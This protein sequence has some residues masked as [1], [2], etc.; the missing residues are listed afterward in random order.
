MA[1]SNITVPAG[2]KS[3][4]EKCLEITAALVFQSSVQVNPQTVEQTFEDALGQSLTLT[5]RVNAPFVL[6]NLGPSTVRVQTAS[7]I[8]P[9]LSGIPVTV[10]FSTEFGGNI[11]FNIL[12]LVTNG[13]SLSG[14]SICGMSLGQPQT[15]S[16]NVVIANNCIQGFPTD[17]SPK[18]IGFDGLNKISG[19]EFLYVPNPLAPSNVDLE[20]I[21][22]RQQVQR[23]TVIYNATGQFEGFVD[24]YTGTSYT[25]L[26]AEAVVSRCKDEDTLEVVSWVEKLMYRPVND[27]AYNIAT[28]A[29]VDVRAGIPVRADGIPPL[30][31]IIPLGLHEFADDGNFFYSAGFVAGQPI[32]RQTFNKI[33]GVL[34][35]PTAAVL[36]PAPGS[37][38]VAGGSLRGMAVDPDDSFTVY[39]IHQAGAVLSLVKADTRTGLME[40]V[41]FI[42]MY[43]IVIPINNTVYELVFTKSGQL[44]MGHGNSL[45]FIDKVTGKVQSIIPF[46]TFTEYGITATNTGIVNLSRYHNGDILVML[47]INTGP[48]IESF[49]LDGDT[50]EIKDAWTAATTNQ[51]LAQ[52]A[53]AYTGNYT[54]IEFNRVYI[55]NLR[56]DEIRYQDHDK[57]TGQDIVLPVTGEVYTQEEEADKDIWLK[58]LCYRLPV[59]VQSL[60]LIYLQTGTGVFGAAF[61]DCNS[62]PGYIPPLG[63]NLGSFTHSQNTNQL[64]ALGTPFPQA[65]STY[66]WSI[67]ATPAFAFTSVIT[68]LVVGNP[69][70]IVRAIRVDPSTNQAY[71]LTGELVGPDV[72][73]RLYTVDTNTG[74]AT[75]IGAFTQITGSIN[76][77]SFAILLDGSA[78]IYTAQ[79]TLQQVHKYNLTTGQR[80]GLQFSWTSSVSTP[81]LRHIQ[82]NPTGPGFVVTMLNNNIS[83]MDLDGNITYLCGNT[84][85]PAQ[86]ALFAPSTQPNVDTEVHK[87][88]RVFTKNNNTGNVSFFDVEMF[89][90]KD[91][92]LPTTALVDT[93][94]CDCGSAASDANQLAPLTPRSIFVDAPGGTFDQGVD[95]PNARSITFVRLSGQIQIDTTPSSTYIID[96]PITLTWGDG[97]D[98]GQPMVNN[99]KFTNVSLGA[100]F[101]V[102][103]VD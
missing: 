15:Q 9:N 62:I 31:G 89:T 41:S 83:T 29:P 77:L 23:W 92:K 71:L 84:A 36:T 55:K 58:D 96:Q 46:K 10:E 39:F 56:T 18:Q 14:E 5:W 13:G 97:R 63:T 19:F 79:A 11:D 45:W 73:V 21:L 37:P 64:Y 51:V 44:V 4:A 42:G 69:T 28:G 85:I 25:S 43:Q 8:A 65:I 95:A 50:Y 54:S 22:E 76:F 6:I 2:G 38:S 98:G 30:A 17:P 3:I 52:P 1:L 75:F 103:W 72:L 35:N 61:S 102:T 24:P 47:E 33:T 57:Y 40:L 67:K 27:I 94:P 87:F 99:I 66:D 34:S 74:A 7:P 82:F 91:I 86:D 100:S 81:P 80:E 48:G 53:I 20:I 59:P 60:G 16:A 70:E 88:T 101:L 93:C 68:G 49:I 32:I 12:N 26:P 90:G 78:Y